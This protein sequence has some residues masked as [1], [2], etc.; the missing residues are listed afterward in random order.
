[1]DGIEGDGTF[2]AYKVFAEGND[3]II[4][5]Q[6]VLHRWMYA[7]VSASNSAKFGTGLSLTYAHKSSFSWR[8]FCDYDYTVKTYTASY[9][10]MAYV[11][12]FSPD[13]YERLKSDTWDPIK[14]WTTSVRKHLHQWVLG[15]ALC[16]S[17]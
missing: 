3:F 10:P 17:F 14:T 6:T 9:A 1:M 4:S 2:A 7:N 15:G 16:V 13:L 12:E 11:E 8:V 5:D